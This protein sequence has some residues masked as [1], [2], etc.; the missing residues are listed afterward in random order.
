MF[1]RFGKSVSNFLASGYVLRLPF[2][3][4]TIQ[5]ILSLLNNLK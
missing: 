3:R 4:E 2:A 1:E 5:Q